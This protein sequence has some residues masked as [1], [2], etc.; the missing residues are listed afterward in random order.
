M[1]ITKRHGTFA[2]ANDV[3]VT[4]HPLPRVFAD[5]KPSTMTLRRLENFPCHVWQGVRQVC[6]VEM[7]N[8]STV[9]TTSVLL[10]GV[11]LETYR[12]SAR[13]T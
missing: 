7:M 2:P 5:S 8:E 3:Q 12:L 11:N 4:T 9:V 13:H 10:C 6:P 1:N